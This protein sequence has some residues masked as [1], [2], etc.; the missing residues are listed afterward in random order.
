M[1]INN[2]PLIFD[3][4]RSDT[5]LG[6]F[7]FAHSGTLDAFYTRIGLYRDDETLR[8]DNFDRH[9]YRR[10]WATSRST[11]MAANIA[12]VKHRCQTPPFQ[13]VRMIVN[14]HRNNPQV[15]IPGCQGQ[16]LCP[17]ETLLASWMP[18]ADDC[19]IDE[20]CEQVDQSTSAFDGR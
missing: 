14:E 13:R 2:I 20:M 3:H 19:D 15:F 18:I 5:K 10:Q 16:S 4:S 1:N 11:P 12:F 17:L 7:R 8:A 6:L 9:R